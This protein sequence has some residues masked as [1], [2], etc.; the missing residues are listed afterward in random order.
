VQFSLSIVYKL[1]RACQ[2]KVNKPKVSEGDLKMSEYKECGYGGYYRGLSEGACF[3]MQPSGVVD[4]DIRGV[5]MV[6]DEAVQPDRSVRDKY[7]Q[8][9]EKCARLV[10]KLIKQRFT[11]A[12]YSSGRVVTARAGGILFGAPARAGGTKLE[13]PASK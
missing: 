1:F 11:S 13:S 5:E 8:R 3:N 2:E 6:E 7:C 9:T 12:E 4:A 10:W